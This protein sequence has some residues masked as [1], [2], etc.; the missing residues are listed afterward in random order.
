MDLNGPKIRNTILLIGTSSDRLILI[1]KLLQTFECSIETLDDNYIDLTNGELNLKHLYPE[2]YQRLYKTNLD[3]IQIY[4]VY[5]EY[6]Y[7][8]SIKFISK[9]SFEFNLNTKLIQNIS[10]TKTDKKVSIEF[11]RNL[12]R[13]IQEYNKL[14][15]ELNLNITYFL[16]SLDD[17][18]IG[19][20]NNDECEM[21]HYVNWTVSN[22]FVAKK[23]MFIFTNTS[24]Y[25][26]STK[27]LNEMIQSTDFTEKYD[28]YNVEYQDFWRCGKIEIGSEWKM[29]TYVIIISI[30]IFGLIIIGIC[31][32]LESDNDILMKKRL[33][34]LFNN[35]YSLSTSSKTTKSSTSNKL[36]L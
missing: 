10:S 29:R 15:M 26:F 23:Q 36:N 19:L 35:E 20:R 34:L 24:I 9:N 8:Y 21:N 32:K 3:S 6:N 5:N 12:I 2:L 22:V 11:N 7:Y 13:F 33:S 1:T 16:C 25:I 30:F 28:L 17:K 18:I 31:V 4:S 14:L 27:I